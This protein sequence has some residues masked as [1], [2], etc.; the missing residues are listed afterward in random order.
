MTNRLNLIDSQMQQTAETVLQVT[1]FL[2]LFIT[3]ATT[4][5]TT[6]R[7]VSPPTAPPIIPPILPGLCVVATLA[8]V[9][10]PLLG[11]GEGAPVT[12]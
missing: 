3:T 6:T 7:T 11:G 12:V 8:S 1:Y 5:T 4:T 9:L 10:V 2:R